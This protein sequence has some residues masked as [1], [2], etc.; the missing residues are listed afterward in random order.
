VS[1]KKAKG[2]SKKYKKIAN[3]AKTLVSLRLKQNKYE[4]ED[5]RTPKKQD[6]LRE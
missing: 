5:S 3:L 6:K 1:S 2:K 4:I